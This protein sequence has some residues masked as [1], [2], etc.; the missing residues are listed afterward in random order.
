MAVTGAT[1]PP[2]PMVRREP[3]D[4]PALLGKRV[5]R[6]ALALLAETAAMGVTVPP[7]PLGPQAGPVRRAKTAW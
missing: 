2:V 1:V 3:P 4:R 6:V 5:H 7:A